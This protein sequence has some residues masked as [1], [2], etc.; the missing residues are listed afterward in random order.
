MLTLL[1]EWKHV[2]VDVTGFSNELS[3]SPTNEKKVYRQKSKLYPHFQ[4]RKHHDIVWVYRTQ[5]DPRK[6]SWCTI[7]QI[8]KEFVY[9]V[10]L[11]RIH[12][13]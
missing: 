12:V 4:N 5:F 9:L 11:L 10:E 3:K 1:V 6:I 8:L 2:S 7:V 13:C